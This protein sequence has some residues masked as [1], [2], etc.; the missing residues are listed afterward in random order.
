MNLL[1]FA[2]PIGWWAVALAVPVILLYVLR[3]RLR[4]QQVSTLLFWDQI[5]ESN[6]PRAWWQQLRRLLSLLLQLAVLALLVSALVDPLWDWQQQRQR[7]VVLILDNSASMQA[8]D[9]EG[10]TRLRAA[11]QAASALV[12]SLRGND[13]MAMLSAE[14]TPRVV[15]GMT[16]HQ[17]GL[18]EA[19]DNLEPTDSPTSLD[20]AVTLAKRLL[21]D[22]EGEGEIIVLTDGCFSA[23]DEWENE[24]RLT[25]Y[26]VG[27]PLDNVGITRYQVRRSL[28]DAVGYQILVDVTN[29][30]EEAQNCRLEL[31][32]EGELV[33]V[34]PLELEPGQTDTRVIDHT[35][36]LGGQ[37]VAELDVD[38]ALDVDNRAVALLPRRDPIPVVLVS[39][40]NLFLK[41]VLE[42]IPLV[43]LTI[44]NE[45]PDA[46]PAGGVLVF[47]RQSPA[48]LPAGRV[49]VVDPQTDTD[50]WKL[51]EPISDPLVGSVDSDSPLTKHV[52]LTNVAFP[53]ARQLDFQVDAAPLIQSAMEQPLFARL[54]RKVGDAVVLTCSLEKGD[55]PLRIA[56]PVL[57][58]NTIEWFM[59]EQGELSPAIPT[60]E[61]L[62]VS[63]APIQAGKPGTAE[64]AVEEA[65]PEAKD[66]DAKLTVV[67]QAPETDEVQYVL[68]SPADSQ[69]PLAAASDRAIIGPLLTTGVW[70]IHNGEDYEKQAAN[71]ATQTDASVEV[72]GVQVACNLVNKRESDLRSRIDISNI[73]ELQLLSLGG[74]SLWFYLTMLS[75]GLIATEWW[76]Y[77]RRIVE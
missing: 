47:D 5:F 42:S 64:P 13:R 38:D 4:R 6:R 77:Q 21:S 26:R 65:D 20:A 53:D 28:L 57:M 24:P 35:S 58:K 32:L 29:H 30:G 37:L 17:S 34:I 39:K 40:G 60:G 50:L 70:S 67:E 9:G 45:S 46:A 23:T 43:D 11:K 3:T 8:V 44:T 7:R 31:T 12:R 62:S 74:H 63:L 61:M 54:P 71:A 1:Q 68:V 69:R 66:A 36:T 41:S 33:D 51:G 15:M 22:I 52:R 76:L 49:L 27:E 19:I 16:D 55:L 2:N 14:G 18:I 25:P 72:P 59:G 48:T 73:D 75:V 56:F 10:T